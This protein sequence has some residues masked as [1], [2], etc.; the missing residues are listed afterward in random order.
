MGLLNY[1]RT[2]NSALCSE[3]PTQVVTSLLGRD[4]KLKT[5]ENKDAR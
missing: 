1:G 3:A 4:K 5:V 2:L